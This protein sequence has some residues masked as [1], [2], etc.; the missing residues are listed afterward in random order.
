ML[1]K[2]A[3]LTVILH[4]CG[5]TR[6]FYLTRHETDRIILRQSARAG[7]RAKKIAALTWDI[8]RRALILGCRQIVVQRAVMNAGKENSES[9]KG[10]I[11]QRL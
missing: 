4:C 6:R 10:L 1:I 5:S 2:T 7:C 3:L 8:D 11:C 9:R